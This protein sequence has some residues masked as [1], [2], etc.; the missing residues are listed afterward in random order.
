MF[1]L[2]VGCVCGGGVFQNCPVL[3]SDVILLPLRLNEFR[4]YGFFFPVCTGMYLCQ[5]EC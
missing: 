5:A 4:F 2:F 1:C 3:S